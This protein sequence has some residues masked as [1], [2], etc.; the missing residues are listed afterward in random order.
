RAEITNITKDKLA[1]FEE[2]KKFTLLPN[3]FT[4][5]SNEITPTL[6]LKRKVINQNYSELIESMYEKAEVSAG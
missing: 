3:E 1:R 4:I 6:K 2:I 5:E